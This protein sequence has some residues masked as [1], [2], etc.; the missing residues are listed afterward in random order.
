MLYKVRKSLRQTPVGETLVWIINHVYSYNSASL[1][2]W[3]LYDFLVMARFRRGLDTRVVVTRQIPQEMAFDLLA[4]FKRSQ[5]MPFRHD[6]HASGYIFHPDREHENVARGKFEWVVLTGETLRCTFALWEHIRPSAESSLGA[7]LEVVN[8]KVQWM[9]PGVGKIGS[10]AWHVDGFPHQFYKI[11]VYLSLT[12]E[13]LG[14][15]EV[16]LPDGRTETVG[17]GMGEWVLFNPNTLPHRGTSL[18]NQE[19]ITVELTVVRRLS[20]QK[21]L[22]FGGTNSAYPRFPWTRMPALA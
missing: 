13:R 6:D 14:G 11:L 3:R 1:F 10:N 21:H 18:P 16:R 4:K 22:R 12:G 8:T 7:P 20:Q 5:R 15:T 17:G 2:Y 19:R 9:Y